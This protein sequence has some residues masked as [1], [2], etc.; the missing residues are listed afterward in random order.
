[1]SNKSKRTKPVSGDD[2]NV[3]R[4]GSRESDE[5]KKGVQFHGVGAEAYNK[6]V[7]KKPE[8]KVVPASF[9]VVS[10]DEVS[11]K[12]DSDSIVKTSGPGI[13]GWNGEKPHYFPADAHEPHG[14]ESFKPLTRG[15]VEKSEEDKVNKVVSKKRGRPPV[16]VKKRQYTLTLHPELYEFATAEAQK[17]GISFSALVTM[18]LKEYLDQ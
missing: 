8:P 15:A 13:G 1:M 10:K 2:E 17:R 9:P 3:D 6:A 16:A 14:A 4:N 12:G 18:A 5:S 11:V 7:G